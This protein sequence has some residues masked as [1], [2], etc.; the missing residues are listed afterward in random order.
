MYHPTKVTIAD[1]DNI[2]AVNIEAWFV[3]ARL[4]IEK[5]HYYGLKV[6]RAITAIGVPISQISDGQLQVPYITTIC[7]TSTPV[8]PVSSTTVTATVPYAVVSTSST[9]PQS[10]GVVQS[11]EVPQT[12]GVFTPVLSSTCSSN[13]IKSVS[14]VVVPE[15]ST[16]SV[17]EV[18]PSYPGL[19]Q[20][21]KG[22]T[23]TSS[24]PRHATTVYFVPRTTTLY[25][26]LVSSTTTTKVTVPTFSVG[27]ST[28]GT[29]TTSGEDTT[30]ET[31]TL[32]TTST[33]I[34]TSTGG[35]GYYAAGAEAVAMVAAVGLALV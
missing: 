16:T 30:T 28:Y 35:V 17:V 25:L 21:P 4:I 11:Y 18:F 33:G 22:F 14:T 15:S 13:T 24:T 12:Y 19:P 20:V 3:L 34:P 32:T 7:T 27:S 6:A 9:V 5:E 31:P 23:N 2:K 26:T 29:P 10:Y 1:L 8:I